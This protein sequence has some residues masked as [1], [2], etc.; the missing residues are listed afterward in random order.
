MCVRARDASY[1]VKERAPEG[2]DDGLEALLESGA[3]AAPADTSSS[4][5][6]EEMGL[7]V[8]NAAL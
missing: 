7:D 1:V 3:Q 2:W 6:G 8:L 4:S 5:S